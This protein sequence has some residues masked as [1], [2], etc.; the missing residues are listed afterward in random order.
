VTIS[1]VIR[2]S[3]KQNRKNAAIFGDPE[4]QSGTGSTHP[5]SGLDHFAAGR[6]TQAK[7]R[8]DTAKE[9]QPVLGPRGLNLGK[10]VQS[11][12]REVGRLRGRSK[13][14]DRLPVKKVPL[15]HEREQLIDFT[16]FE[17]AADEFDE[18]VG[19]SRRLVSELFSVDVVDAQDAT[20]S[21]AAKQEYRQTRRQGFESRRRRHGFGRGRTE[22][23]PDPERPEVRL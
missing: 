9:P 7:R 19:E 2:T 11:E 14:E 5:R 13:A 21:Q 10:E 4:I 16:D 8:I 1:Q 17:S 18:K 3:K 12:V 22:P 23:L 6:R 20:S 15:R